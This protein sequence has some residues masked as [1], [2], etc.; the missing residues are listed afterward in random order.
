MS[1]SIAK[2]SDQSWRV[3]FEN[4]PSGQQDIFYSPSF[5]KVC[6][7]TT[8]EGD[9]VLGAIFSSNSGMALY[10]FCKRSLA[11][12]SGFHDYIDHFDITSLY[13]RGGI[14]SSFAN[15]NDMAPFYAAFSKYCR[16][17]H[18]IC[19]FDRFHPIIKNEV[20]SIPGGEVRDIGGFV[21]VDLTPSLVKIEANLKSSVR[22][23]IRKAE[24]N[25]IFCFSE[26]NTN[27]LKEFLQI[28]YHTMGRNAA[29]QFY[30]FKENYFLAMEK[31]M[32][33]KFRYFYALA[34]QE[35]VSCEL[36]LHH[37][38]Y[39][40]SFLGGTKRDALPLAANPILKLEIIKFYKE[41]GCKYYMLGG[42]SAPDDGIFNF[43]KAYAPE[44]VYPSFV[45]GVIWDQQVYDQLREDMIS[46][47]AT[48]PTSRFQFYDNG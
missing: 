7:L 36:V 32:P 2:P 18:I 39:C 48:L 22:K 41:L 42:G 17:A 16:N 14:V 3:L 21:I 47:G 38:D 29:D 28:Y 19:G 46:S 44:G 45:G 13:G 35:I 27:H 31:E 43:K 37:G 12:V 33:G 5:A 11:R 8:N 30:Y 34:G 1:F 26:G 15:L 9:E 6:Q 10:P 24:R 25:G 40:H 4:L 23:D 20:F